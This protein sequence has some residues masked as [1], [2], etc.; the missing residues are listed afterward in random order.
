MTDDDDL[1]DEMLAAWLYGFLASFEP[2]DNPDI[3]DPGSA[4]ALYAAALAMLRRLGGGEEI[5]TVLADHMLGNLPARLTDTRRFMNY[6]EC[7]AKFA[8]RPGKVSEA[9]GDE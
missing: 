4:A 6:G 3:A 1:T 7:H 8:R 2:R 9:A 5:D